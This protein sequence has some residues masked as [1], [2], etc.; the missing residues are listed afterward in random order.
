MLGSFGNTRVIVANFFTPSY[1]IVGRVEVFTSGLVGLL[2]DPTTAFLKIEEAS[3]ARL[4][5]PKRL[6]DRVA[7]VRMVKRGLVAVALGRRE[8]VGPESVA[9][10]GFGRNT[11]H[12][13]RAITADYELEGTL[14][15]SG[16]L[17]FTIM[18]TEGGEFIPLYDVK[19]RAIQFADLYLEAP[20]VLFNRRKVDMINLLSGG[21]GIS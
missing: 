15:W 2:N 3:M 6:A 1:R 12:Q 20:A 14:E 7:Q 19:F 16:R 21:Q 8:D 10:G 11:P 4:N 13:I 9:R 17:D 5:E 18:L